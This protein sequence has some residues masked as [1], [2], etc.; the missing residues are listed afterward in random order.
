MKPPL[1]FCV[2]CTWQVLFGSVMQLLVHRIMPSECP[3]ENTK[4]LWLDIKDVYRRE[5]TDARFSTMKMSM[6]SAK[7]CAKLRGTAA[8][9]RAHGKVLYEVWC[10]YWNEDLLLHQ[11]IELC[12]RTGCHLEKLLDDNKSEYALPGL[13][14]SVCSCCSFDVWDLS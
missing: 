7:G 3:L 1:A 2:L 14:E 9:I 5:K 10:K 12:L 13:L 4:Q 8:N 11:R 6:F